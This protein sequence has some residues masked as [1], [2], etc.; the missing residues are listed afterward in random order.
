MALGTGSIAFTGFN[1]DGNDNLAFVT[2]EDIPAGT[3]IY[4]SDN[5]WNGTGWADFAENVFSWT[6][7]ATVAAGSIVQLNSIGVAGGTSPQGTIAAVAGGGTNLGVGNSGEMIYAYIADAGTPLAPTTFL[8]AV[9]N[10]SGTSGSLTNTGLIYGVN[11]I[12][13]SAIN[14]DADIGAY[15]GSRSDQTTMTDYRTVINTATNWITQ[16]A[17]GDQSIDGTAPDVP[18]STTAFTLATPGQTIQFAAGSLAVSKAEG[19]DGTR[20]LSFT[21]S[22]AGGTTGQLDFSGSFAAGTTDAA[23]FGGSLPTFSGSIAAGATTAVVTITISGDTSVE[24]NEAFTLTLTGGSNSAGAAVT[25][26]ANSAATGTILND[27]L[28]ASVGGITIY[29][30]AASLAG[31]ATTPTATNDVVLVRLGSIAGATAGAESTAYENGKIYATNINGNAINVHAVSAT[32]AL[33]N[34]APISLTGLTDYKTGGVNSVAV[35]DGVIAVAYE[36]ATAGQGGY[37]ALFDANNGNALIKTIQVGVL[38][39]MVTFSPDGTKILVANEG[40]ALSVANDPAGSISII[41]LS[42]GA[43]N[44]AVSNTISF[45]ALNGWE[46]ALRANGLALLPGQAASTD[47][48]PEYITVSADGTRAYVTLQEVNAVAVIDLTNPSATAPIAIQP[49]GAIDRNLVGNAFDA[50][51]QDGIDIA[52][53]D[54][55]SLAQPDAIA[56]YS[57]GGVTY[58]ITAN[59]GDARAN[60]TTD[61]VR[62]SSASYVLDPTAYPNAAALKAN[63]ELGRLNVLTNVGDTD[64][65]GDFDQIYTLGGRGISIFR[66]EAD[67]SITKVR[68]TGGEF[69]AITAQLAPTLFNSNQSTA[70]SSVDT[71]SDDKGP[72]PEGVSIGEINGHVYAF[73]GLERIGGYMVYDVT[74]PANAQF[75]SYKPE[76]SADLGPETSVFISADDSPT[77]QALLVSGQEISNTVTLYSIQTQSEG[78]DT[79][80]GGADAETWNGRGGNDS[81]RGNGGNDSIDGGTGTDTAVFSGNFADY[82]AT[83]NGTSVTLTGADGTDTVVNVEQFQFDDGTFTVGQVGNVGPL[84]TSAS[85]FSVSENATAAAALTASDDNGDTLTYAITGG[86]DADLFSIDAT[87]GVVTFKVAP[88][89]EAPADAG[90]DNVYDIDVAVDDGNGLVGEASL[91]IT[92]GNVNENPALTAPQAVLAHGTEDVAYIVSSADLLTGFTDVDGDTLSVANLTASSGLLTDNL[93]GTYTITQAANAHGAI[94]LDYDVEDGNGG[95]IAATLGYVVDAV[96]DAPTDITVSGGSVAENS[97]N[98]TVVGVFAGVDPDGGSLTYSLVDN[99]GGRFAINATTGVLTVAS[100]VLLDFEAASSHQ[101]TVAVSDGTASYSENF[102]IAVTDVSEARIFNGTTASDSFTA[103]AGSLDHWTVDGKAGNDV[104]STADGNDLIVAGAG[105]DTYNAGGGNDVITF[106]GTLAANGMDSIDGGAGFDEIR[107]LGAYTTM[108]FASLSNVEKIN[109]NGFASVAIVGTSGND[110]MDFSAI[111]VTGIAAIKGGAGA[112]TII[113]SAGTDIIWGEAGN[114]SLN[115]GGGTDIFLIGTGAGFDS[116]DGGAGHDL[117]KAAADNVKIGL[118]VIAGIETIEGSGFANVTIVGQSTGDALDLSGIT[119]TDISAINLGGGNDSLQGSDSDDVII[120][121]AGMDTL[122]G[123]LGADSFRYAAFADSKGASIDLITDFVTGED[124]IDLSALDANSKV[125]GNQAFT[126]MGNGAFDHSAGEVR[127]DYDSGSNLTKVLAD[128]NGDTKIDFE[129]HLS[130][131]VALVQADFIL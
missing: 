83:R 75:V 28:P 19:D 65:D 67:G 131:N 13:L 5:E 48:E 130:G 124:K 34:L 17:S 4:F 49:L 52:N 33:S 38:P 99:A 73:V 25:V 37:I 101:I 18:F 23:D 100:T 59:E 94:T 98:G 85:A 71:R 35:K 115:G 127:F 89:F 72:E 20:T 90:A 3:V 93:D 110:I 14:V 76:T 43:A 36:N 103:P 112:D 111:T 79:I 11:A 39:D 116:F 7:T 42:T 128:I 64:G 46:E 47:I 109:G 26:G 31:S 40:E 10:N 60:I 12:D 120:G 44:A 8:T 117:I 78:D 126:F 66:Q 125:P 70:A 41:D 95:S 55:Y 108:S 107:A 56:S 129:I 57:V 122:G 118:A 61:V 51:D 97:A 82:T 27:D 2:F 21:V 88:D 102:A 69:E 9:S 22:R 45:A 24:S 86:A 92:V 114:D 96:N 105:N 84:F 54:V 106:K 74:D 91:A 119:I 63:T 121:G 123:G 6:A 15:T 68:E 50:S 29:D 58:F 1:G 113:G 32:G 16:N 53:F 81:I 104:I 30:P 80:I 87:T 62:L 77:G